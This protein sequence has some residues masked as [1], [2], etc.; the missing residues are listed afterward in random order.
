MVLVL[1]LPGNAIIIQAYAWKKRKASTD[2]LIMAQAIVDFVACL[3]TPVF[4]I[5]SG[6]PKLITTG[7]CRMSPLAEE[8]PAF[9]SLFLTTVISIDRYMAVCHPLRRR[10]TVRMTIVLVTL[11]VVVS[12]AFNIPLVVLSQVRFSDTVK[13]R[14][15]DISLRKET[16]HVVLAATCSIYALF[17]CSIMTT[18]VLYAFIYNFLR[19]RAKIHAGLVD[20]ELP[21]ATISSENQST[22]TLDH[23]F[24]PGAESTDFG[25]VTATK[26]A[27]QHLHVATEGCSN[28]TN[29]TSAPSSKVMDSHF[30]SPIIEPSQD[31]LKQ[32]PLR[33]TLTE[34][35]HS[36]AS[37][38][39]RSLFRRRGTNQPKVLRKKQEADYG[40]KT[41]R[42]LLIISIFFF[43]TWTPSMIIPIIP[44]SIVSNGRDIPGFFTIINILIALKLT[45][46]IVNFFVYYWVSNSFR[47]DVK[48]SFKKCRGRE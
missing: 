18:T 35:H 19:K 15:C 17:I 8:A 45:N 44:R 39:K 34:V 26:K 2:I 14:L 3:F 25:G 28:N 29:I 9:M 48:E 38:P 23:V 1:G 6:F 4:I 12:I 41:T 20:N 24:V 11:C 47:R 30:M 13:R 31:N 21:V 10:M 5:R 7:L 40:R 22:G 37:S 16:Y 42:M 32:L 43:L 33:R 27:V 36:P 46:H